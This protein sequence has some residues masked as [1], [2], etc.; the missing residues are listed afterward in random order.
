M[1]TSQSVAWKLS[2]LITEY[3]LSL[4]GNIQQPAICS[5]VWDGKK[6]RGSCYRYNSSQFKPWAMRT[7]LHTGWLRLVLF[8]PA[9][10]P[11]RRSW[12]ERGSWLMLRR[13]TASLRCI[14]PLST[15]TETLP[16]SSSRRW[17]EETGF[18]WKLV[19]SLLLLFIFKL[20]QN[21]ICSTVYNHHFFYTFS[22][23]FKTTFYF[24]V[25]VSGMELKF[26]PSLLFHRDAVTSTSA[27]IATRRRCSW[28]WLRATP[29]WCSCWWPRALTSTWRTRMVTRPCMWPSSARSWPTLCSAP[30][31]EP[32]AVRR[33]ARG[34]LPHH[35]TAGW[36]L[37]ETV[38]KENTGVT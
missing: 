36:E 9:A 30:P 18:I 2:Y 32:A 22:V 8:V 5:S 15:T 10:G 37:T 12:P 19:F 3:C 31:W 6:H 1:L 29:N 27:T 34:V 13:R 11:Q 25:H 35:F 24:L 26:F 4:D 7:V 28:R 16:R 17:A 23:A 33:A 21:K 20:I 14:W 38:L